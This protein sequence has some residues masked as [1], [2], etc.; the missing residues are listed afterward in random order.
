MALIEIVSPGNKA[1]DYAF[2]TLVT[3]IA[4]ALYRGLHVLVLDL[5][6]PTRRDP[7]GVHAAVWAAIGAGE[8]VPPEGRRLTLASYEAGP[9]KVAYVEPKMGFAVKFNEL[10]GEGTEEVQ[11]LLDALGGRD[12]KT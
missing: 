7:N 2:Q 11:R 6:P 5:L 12:G 4:G 9:V 8:F 3:K 10:D 1:S